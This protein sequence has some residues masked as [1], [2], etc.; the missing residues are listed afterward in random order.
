MM[1]RRSDKRKSVSSCYTPCSFVPRS[2]MGAAL[3][4]EKL[5]NR[6]DGRRVRGPD[7][8]FGR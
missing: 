2:M 8:H 7:T 6:G 5:M 1:Q 4:G 3:K